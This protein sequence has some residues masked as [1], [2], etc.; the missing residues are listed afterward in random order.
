[1]SVI[2]A[3]VLGGSF[4]PDEI[5]V[6]PGTLREF[7]PAQESSYEGKTSWRS[8]TV[9]SLED[10]DDEV[11]IYINVSSRHAKGNFAKLYKAMTG[12]EIPKSG[13]IDARPWIGERRNVHY[14]T[15]NNPSNPQ[16]IGVVGFSRIRQ[17]KPIQRPAA[18]PPQDNLFSDETHG[19]EPPF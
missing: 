2:D 3:P 16:A 7:N 11:H 18:P 17:A 10:F 4:G 1:M 5:G 13:P 8:K 12:N 6:Y 14:D 15:G 19:E 9:W